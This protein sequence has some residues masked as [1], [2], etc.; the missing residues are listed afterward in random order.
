MQTTKFLLSAFL[1][2]A[3]ASL[4]GGG[5]AMA[6]PTDSWAWK[7][8]PLIVFAPDS[9][10]AQLAEQRKRLS[11]VHGE[12][13]E[14]DMTLIEIVG[15]RANVVFGPAVEIDAAALMDALKV[16]GDRFEVVLLGKDTGV[17]LK[18]DSP[19]T[20]QDLFSLIDQ[21]PMRRREMNRGA[22]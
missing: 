20:S 19:V 10:N 15:K 17:K 18:S 3:I 16:R 11:P 14:R 1:A 5:N 7:Y 22:S 4:V 13:R 2:L 6:S 8:R 12:L 21:M 9:Q